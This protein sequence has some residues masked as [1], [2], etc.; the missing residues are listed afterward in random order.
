MSNKKNDYL[1][2]I[3]KSERKQLIT[4]LYSNQNGYCFICLEKVDID[5]CDKIDVTKLKNKIQKNKSFIVVD[6]HL[7]YFRIG[8]SQFFN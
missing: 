1:N 2:T 3:S 5:L 7:T 6:D 4:K 8:K